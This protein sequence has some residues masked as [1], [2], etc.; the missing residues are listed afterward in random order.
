MRTCHI[1]CAMPMEC[2]LQMK[3]GDLLIAADAGYLNLLSQKVRPDLVVGD[4]DS[5]GY[6]PEQVPIQKHPVRKDDTDTLLSIRIGLEQGC[7][8][9]LLYGA[10]GGRIDHTIANIQSLAFIANRGAE[11]YLAGN[12]MMTVFKTGELVFPR[13]FS[14]TISVFALGG[15][16]QS[17]S[18][19]N[20]SFPFLGELETD[21]PLGV[22][23]RFIG[24][25]A[26]IS[27][28]DGSLL[29]IWSGQERFALP[30]LRH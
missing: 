4:F 1:V 10:T 18:I 6:V 5:L 16:A 14:G 8:R 20:L 15:R 27:V 30:V 26:R 12:E 24:E 9:F 7:D 29:V 3:E 13:T 25:E 28:S 21:Y 23:N 19:Q 22:S 11:G 2:G 17:V